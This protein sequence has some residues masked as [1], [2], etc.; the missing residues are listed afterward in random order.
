MSGNTAYPTQWACQVGLPSSICVSRL[1]RPWR[2]SAVISGI[3]EVSGASRGA[4]RPA[5]GDLTNGTYGQEGR[6][7]VHPTH[8]VVRMSAQAGKTARASRRGGCRRGAR[9]RGLRASGSRLRVGGIAGSA[10]WRARPVAGV[11]LLVRAIGASTQFSVEML[12]F[13]SCLKLAVSCVCCHATI[14]QAHVNGL[15]TRE[16]AWTVLPIAFNHY[17]TTLAQASR[18]CQTRL[19]APLSYVAVRPLKQR[20][21]PAAHPPSSPRPPASAPPRPRKRAPR[22]SHPR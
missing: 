9:V 3:G 19:S 12:F 4:G 21:T 13:F 8:C 20:N 5:A 7:T 17:T 22:R 16:Q 2:K 11:L 18:T 1:P 15:D 14:T 6:R 10:G